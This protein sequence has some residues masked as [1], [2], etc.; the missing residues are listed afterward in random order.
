MHHPSVLYGVQGTGNGHISRARLMAVEFNRLG[1]NVEYLFSGRPQNSYFDMDDFTQPRFGTGLSFVTS[2]GRIHKLKTLKNNQPIRY[3]REVSALRTDRH[4]LVISDFEPTVAWAAQLRKTPTLAIGHQYALDAAAPRPQGELFAKWVLRNFAPAEH[5]IGFHWHP[6]SRLTL[7]PMIDT[8]LTPIRNSQSFTLV[9]LPFED[10]K[11]TVAL[12]QQ[13]RGEHF[14]MYSPDASSETQSRN[15]SI[16]PLSKH[17]FRHHLQR[18][19]RVICNTGFELI[20]EALHLGV[21]VLTRPLGGQFEQQANAMALKE[22]GLATVTRNL[23]VL[24]LDTFIHATLPRRRTVY[25]NV[26]REL[27]TFCLHRISG[28]LDSEQIDAALEDM[29]RRL[30]A[31][32]GQ[33][34]GDSPRPD[35][36]DLPTRL[37]AA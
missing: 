15:V 28:E 17:G 35:N 1:V 5:S 25:P 10:Q 31:Q 27:A 22:L 29:A 36:P 4:D 32:V 37:A 20:A 19:N 24:N 7:P 6:Y 9:Y 33:L 16:Y 3:A 34:P 13:I 18:C 11:E 21:P 23:G 26:A 30:W 8:S 2:Q 12:L 14:V